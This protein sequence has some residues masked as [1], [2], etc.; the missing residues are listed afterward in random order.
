[1]FLEEYDVIVV[2]AGHAGCEAAA[3]AANL[4]CSTLLVTMSLQNIAQMSCNPAM[5]GI[6]KGQI[7]REIDALGGYSGIVSDNTAI[8][9]KM[10]NKSKG[11]AMWSP[12]VQSDRMRFAEEWRLMLEGTPNLDFYQEMV[13][14]MVIENNK[15][16]GIKTS[17]GLTIRGK[18]VVLT[19]GTFLNG[20]IHIGDKQ[21]GG[22]RAGES[23]A[24]GITEDLVK[25]GFESG[26][27]K[28]GTPPRVDGRSLDYSKMNVE[29]GDINPSKFSYSDVTKPLV[30]QR[31]CH[32]TYTSLLVHDILREGFERSP[33]FNGRIK[34]LG[35]RYCPSIE[36]KINRFADKD[37]HQLFVEPE[38]WNTCEVYVNG[39]STSLPEDIQFKALRSVVGFE[40]VKFFRAGYAI[41]Y[42]YFPPTQLKHTLETKLISGLYFAG[43][44]NGT[45]GYEE[46]ASQGLMAG[47]NAALKVKEKEPLILK[48]D[49]AYIGVLIDD[50]ITKGTE[51]PY[52]MFTSRAEFRTL[53][54]QDNADFRLTPMSN[55]LGLASDARLRRM[56]HKLNE[57]EKMVAFF[58]ET[59]I[60][61]TEAN[62]VLI[63]KK[64]A[65]VN[66]TD[67]IFKI[68]SRPQIDLSDV[69]KFENVANYV[70][71]NNVDQEILEQAEIQVKYSGYIDK[72]RANAEKLTR[73]ED[74]KI[75]EKFDYHQIKSMSI[76][77]KQKLSKIRPVTISQASRISG[78]SPSDISVLLVFLGR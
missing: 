4:G 22:G 27:M 54:R 72:E 19:N 50:L 11:P 65:E 14:G 24:Y 21:F 26:R 45:T 1:M 55:T 32:M 66:Q 75:P 68:L 38:G 6:A 67:K 34:S 35:P 2:G 63:A 59:S 8:Q 33:M 76:E 61:P 51:E 74:L 16:L 39:F 31:D 58:K 10:L 15:V 41:E 70:A 9:F 30:H 25:A 40:K 3:A 43:Q 7:V 71:S 44:I 49:E 57:S 62:P 28:T 73:L 42:D 18:S 13:S 17:L 56:E 52:R 47:I 12:R 53:L 20:L 64:T 36:D 77:A 78:V 29:A 48:R 37:R 46:A 60:T 23:A 69:L 5:G